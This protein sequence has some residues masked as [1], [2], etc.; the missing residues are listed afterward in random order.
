MLYPLARSLMFRFDPETSHEVALH[1]MNIASDLGFHKLMGA[2]EISDPV[3]VMGLSFPNR[4]GLAAGLDKNGIAVD[5][6]AA[7]GFG[8]VEVGT[9]TPRPQA[10][11]PKPRLFRLP[12][13]NAIINRMGFNN[14]GVDHLLKN[15]QKSTYK[16]ILGINIGKNKDTPNEKA[17]DDYLYCMRKVYDRASYITVNVSSP[18]T[19]GLR[20]LQYGESLNSLLDALKSEQVRQ[21]KLHDRYVPI[22]VKIAPDMEEEE[23]EMVASSLK[24]YE[25]DAVIATN[26]TLSREG[27]EGSPFAQEAGGLSGAPVRNKST[28]AIRILSNALDGALP[29]IGVGGITEGFDAAEKIEAGASLVQIYSGFI[30]HG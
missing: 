13:Q 14:D 24:A 23:F 18:N 26:T 27:V 8:F 25:M 17:N 21:A 2:A 4:V 3:E 11:N 29:I 20:T 5:G 22:A 12:E 1:T 19:P 30:Y 10:G 15:L 16:G 9:V 7:M 28:R 6:L